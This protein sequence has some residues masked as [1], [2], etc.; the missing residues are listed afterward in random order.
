MAT[1]HVIEF[2]PF[3]GGQKKI[4]RTPAKR[5]VIRAGRRFGKTTMLEQ[6]A[7][8]WSAQQMRVGWFAPSYKILLPSY[9]AIRDQLKPITISA[10]KT[11]MIIELIGGGHVEFW[12]LDNPDAGRSR[13]YHKIIID[14]GSL[15]KKG[16]RDIWEQAIEPTLLDYDGDAIMAGTPKGVD[17]ENFFYQ[18]CNDKSLGWEEHHTPTSA[19]PTL[20]PEAL[21]RIT[22]GKP[23]MVIQQEYQAM[24]VDWRGQNF[25][26]L[27][28]LLENGAPV[29][30]PVGCDTVYGVVDCAQKGGLAHDGSAVI[31][32]ALNN[33]PEPHLVILDWDIIQIDGYFLQKII[34]QWIARS[35]HL[36]EICLARFGTL[37]LY[38]EDKST[39]TTLLQQGANEG[40]NVQPIDS[41]MTGLG[42]EERAINIS[43]YVASGKVRISKYAFDK[44]TEHKDSKKNHL[45]TQ[46]LQF[47]IGE[48]DQ[49]DDLFDCFNY[50]VA[51][52]LGNGDGF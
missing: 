12:T 11:D 13:K 37:G 42:K 41:A 38:I 43:G 16:M 9:K 15:V 44:I 5:K 27:D 35:K 40:W 4:Y 17:D 46:V 25:F 47:I 45:L 26:K 28:W 52:G 50:G 22:A 1:E 49:A 36:S 2:L 39:G 19:N 23:P 31:W 20:N 18:A 24:F 34:P 6:C 48:K 29:D 51:L 10:S 3:H 8:N 30:Y 21:A 33:I 7:G 32:F 14:E